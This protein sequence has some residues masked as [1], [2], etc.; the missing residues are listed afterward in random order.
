MSCFERGSRIE[1]IASNTKSALLPKCH[2]GLLKRTHGTLVY[3]YIQPTDTYRVIIIRNKIYV[4]T[5]LLF[6]QSAVNV[7]NLPDNYM[8]SKQ[9]N[10]HP[11]Y[12]ILNYSLVVMQ[13]NIFNF[14]LHK[15]IIAQTNRTSFI[16]K[17]RF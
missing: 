11:Y 10:Y 2:A 6:I 3:H 15:T 8:Q 14:F 4:M 12:I 5:L 17:N 1:T 13:L 9:I 7:Q 16:F